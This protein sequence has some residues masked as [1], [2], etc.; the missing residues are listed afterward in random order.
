MSSLSLG[1][2]PDQTSETPIRPARVATALSWSPERMPTVA[3]PRPRKPATAAAASSLTVSDTAKRPMTAPP[4]RTTSPVAPRA[5]IVSRHSARRGGK[6]AAPPIISGLPTS[7]TWPS[8]S[9]RSPSPASA[10]RESANRASTPAA[11]A[12]SSTAVASGWLQWRSRQ[13]AQ[14]RTSASPTPSAGIT[15]S[16]TGRPRVRVPVLSKSATS[17]RATS[18]RYWPPFIRMPRLAAR[19]MAATVAVGAAM[20]SAQGQPATSTATAR[21]ALP[22]RSQARAAQAKTRGVK[23]LA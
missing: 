3:S 16:T 18:S 7:T 11:L 12:A 17:A 22:L 13:A 6:A 21:S 1:L 9:P 8:S 20:S 10:V 14:P 4:F 15:A 19:P 23:Y 5:H 2:S